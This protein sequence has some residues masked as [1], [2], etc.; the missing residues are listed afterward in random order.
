VLAIA[1]DIQDLGYQGALHGLLSLGANAE[2]DYAPAHYP[3]V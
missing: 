3:R 2:G 1:V